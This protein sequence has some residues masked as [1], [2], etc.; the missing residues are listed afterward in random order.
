MSEVIKKDN[1]ATGSANNTGS[2]APAAIG[3][4]GG[5][6]PTP[7]GVPTPG[8]ATGA[9]R[10]LA[11]SLRGLFRNDLGFLPVLL[12]LAII[13][14]FF[15]AASGGDFFRPQ[16]LSNLI[17][18]T[19]TTGVLAIGAAMVLF[20]GEIDLSLAAVS[21]TCAGAMAVLVS[22]AAEG[23]RGV[24]LNPWL[25]ILLAL[26]LGAII[27]F[28]NGFFIAVIRV[29]S[30]IVTLAGSIGYA[31]LLLV[32]LGPN[33]TLKINN[34]T[35]NGL[36]STYLPTWLGFGLPGLVVLLYVVSQIA[37]RNSRQKVGLRVK[38]G[39][40]MA[41]EL[42]ALAVV[43]ALIVFSLQ[44]YNGVPLVGVIWLAL[45]I[46]FWLMLTRSSFGR[47]IYAVGGNVEASRRAGINVT[48]LK[49]S[50]FTIASTMAAVSGVLEASRE[51]SAP[52][53]INPTLLL[54]A[55]AA[56]V[57]GGI[58]LFGGKGSIWAILLG[59]LIVKSL[60]N[61]LT[62]LNQTQEVV[63]IVQGVVLL[64][65]VT[66]DAVLRRNNNNNVKR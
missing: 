43:I 1:A 45:I 63:E 2:A 66:L 59:S 35:V 38:S 40:Q 9:N 47:H 11:A 49:I 39:S 51:N 16:N 58:S 13:M 54:N 21:Y 50:I 52:A 22:P 19:I 48:A 44:S 17:L 31:G 18:Q 14:I 15:Q 60:E 32:I 20:L 8:D 26:L 65:A 10:S 4:G 42:G 27:G 61:G 12:T 6:A 3:G 30:F 34:S 55:I 53:A 41:I 64:L 23:T 33:S 57:I 56:A 29:P 7:P 28:V 24:G 5:A 36:S 37:N 46:G 62:L 25:S